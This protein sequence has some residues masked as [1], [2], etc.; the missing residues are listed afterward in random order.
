MPDLWKRLALIANG[1]FTGVVES[2]NTAIEKRGHVTSPAPPGA[3]STGWVALL[4]NRRGL[5]GGERLPFCKVYEMIVAIPS[6]VR[7]SHLKENLMTHAHRVRSAWRQSAVAGHVILGFLAASALASAAAAESNNAVPQFAS[8]EFG[9]Q[10]NVADWREPPP[11]HGHGPIAPDPA[12]PFTSNAEAARA[13]TQPTKRIGNAKD[14]VLK[15]WAATLMQASND[16]ALRSEMAIPFA[17]QARCY[18]GGVPGQLLYPFEPVYFIQTPK[19]VWMM[20]QRDHMVRRIFLADQHSEH[21]TPSWFGESI[22][23]YEN[24]TLVVDTVGLST[25]NS[26]IDNFRTPHTEKLHVVERFSI[27]PGGKNMTAL[28]TVE[29]PDTFNAPLTMVQR[30]FKVDSPIKETV[31]SENNL[32]YFNQGLFPIPEAAKPDF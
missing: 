19:E 10:T 2:L 12:H 27:E 15:P 25:K 5:A 1:L 20:W 16:A 26:Y 9:W 24:G 28:V 3:A 32:D 8:A 23:H 18:P 14:P 13:G 7:R 6:G 31:C 22:G 29:D 11:G 17:A 4:V 30:W 21:V